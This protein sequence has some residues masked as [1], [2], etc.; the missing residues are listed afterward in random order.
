MQDDQREIRSLLREELEEELRSMG[1]PAYR[2]EQIFRW[3]H[4]GAGSFAEMS[5]LPK[6]LREALEERFR[7]AAPTV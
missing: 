2:A 3:L 5:D 6:A 4:R 7:L 1:L